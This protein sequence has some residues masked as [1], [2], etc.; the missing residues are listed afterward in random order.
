MSVTG[1]KPHDRAEQRDQQESAVHDTAGEPD[2]ATRH[3]SEHDEEA[4]EA[5][6][7]HADQFFQCPPDHQRSTGRATMGDQG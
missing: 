6:R 4:D 1:E 5:C 3:V 2:Q 7:Q